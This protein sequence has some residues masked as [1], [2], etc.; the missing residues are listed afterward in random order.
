MEG[1]GEGC[2][3]QE[4]AEN[5]VK[6]FLGRGE[7]V[8]EDDKGS[9]VFSYRASYNEG[10]KVLFIRH[11]EGPKKLELLSG[12]VKNVENM[13]NFIFRYQ[14]GK[15]GYLESCD[16]IT[17]LF[18][19][20]EQRRCI[21]NSPDYIKLKEDFLTP[22]VIVAQFKDVV[23]E[24]VNTA[25]ASDS[26]FSKTKER[27]ALTPPTEIV[28]TLTQHQIDEGVVSIT[29]G[30]RC[31]L[32]FYELKGG[33]EL[34][35]YGGYAL[36]GSID[37]ALGRIEGPDIRQWFLEN[38]LQA[39]EKIHIRAP[40]AN[41]RSLSIY[42]FFERPNIVAQ[43]HEG[44]DQRESLR[45]R[46]EIYELFRAK[47]E[48]LH[49]S[50]IYKEL[51]R[52][53]HRDIEQ[54]AVASTLYANKHLFRKLGETRLWGLVGWETLQSPER[55]DKQSLLLALQEDDMVYRTLHARGMFV[56]AKD[57]A[58][59]LGR[60]FH[61]NRRDVLEATF[62]DVKDK[63]IIRNR[64]GEFGL[65]EWIDRWRTELRTAIAKLEKRKVLET[66]RGTAEN[67][68]RQLTAEVEGLDCQKQEVTASLGH[69][70]ER[71]D[72]LSVEHAALS[73]SLEQ[74]TAAIRTNNYSQTTKDARRRIWVLILA[75]LIAFLCVLS[76]VVWSTSRVVQLISYGLI[77]C[78]Y[79][80]AVS[81]INK[82]RRRITAARDAY[83]SRVMKAQHL[84]E[85]L[86]QIE[87]AKSSILSE[88]TQTGEGVRALDES[89]GLKQKVFSDLQTNL[90]ALAEELEG[91][92]GERLLDEKRKYE[93]LL[94][95]VPLDN[96]EEHVWELQR[97]TTTL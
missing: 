83:G 74:L 70:I 6:L 84:Q 52:R 28:N 72:Q 43:T 17:V 45:L 75:C 33:V 61:I 79:W 5:A 30:L 50:E 66:E 49:I 16:L 38:G 20:G 97:T 27:W 3:T 34:I 68:L 44:R 11:S 37:E 71:E 92:D 85:E 69:L 86:T 89:L 14:K 23:L 67:R 87:S 8:P 40:E 94:R 22:E 7:W 62:I 77:A 41:G 4:L 91:Y 46:H 10:E 56:S 55:L 21:C 93:S 26:R 95:D 48:F 63:R 57:I 47:G 24:K 51:N 64:Q 39:G 76:L 2:S 32:R 18:P 59:E 9:K 42:T 13:R 80:V 36:K 65:R 82:Q 81:Y 60:Y 25:L 1:K 12:T 53:L 90:H 54:S 88:R 19:R 35:A 58:E 96:Q 73:S 78:I 29:N 31:I 15:S